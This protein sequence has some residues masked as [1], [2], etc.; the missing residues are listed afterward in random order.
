M[1]TEQLADITL[2]HRQPRS[3][4]IEKGLI[5]SPGYGLNEFTVP[6]FDG[7]MRRMFPLEALQD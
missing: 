1:S 3:R 5:F 7:F 4:L 2:S 6:Q